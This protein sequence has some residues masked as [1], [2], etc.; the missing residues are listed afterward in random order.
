MPFGLIASAAVSIG[1]HL[2]GGHLVKAAVAGAPSSIF[3]LAE[4][5]GLRGVIIF[6]ATLWGT[7]PT[8]RTAINNLIAAV[9]EVFI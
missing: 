6:M 2:L 4:G 8:V 1:K 7:Q 9:T 5:F 3:S